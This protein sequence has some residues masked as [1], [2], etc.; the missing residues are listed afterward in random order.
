[1]IMS[2]LSTDLRQQVRVV[3]GVSDSKRCHLGYTAVRYSLQSVS[4][5]NE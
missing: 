5:V 1:M 3:C 4:D 2:R